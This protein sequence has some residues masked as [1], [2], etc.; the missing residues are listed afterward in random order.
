[1]QRSSGRRREAS[2]VCQ[3]EQ[4]RAKRIASDRD[5]GYASAVVSEATHADPADG[6]SRDIERIVSA[7]GERVVQ[8]LADGDT[9]APLTLDAIGAAVREA[10]G[11]LAAALVRAERLAW[12]GRQTAT[13]VHE[14]R[15]PLSVIETSAFIVSEAARGNE[16][17]LR[18]AQRIS[19]QVARASALVA[20]LL[21]GVRDDAA[22]AGPVDVGAVVRRAVATVPRPPGVQLALDVPSA[23]P[24]AHAESRRLGQIVVNLLQNALD[25]LGGTGHITVEVVAAAQQVIVRVADSGPGIDPSVLAGLFDPLVTAKSRGTGLGLAFARDTV[26]AWGGD[27]VAAGA[28]RRGARF[29]VGLQLAPPG[30]T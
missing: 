24:L 27:L 16:R 8:T 20:D 13:V 3:R 5:S 25:A 21:A 14:L 7:I 1:M 11:P 19:E 26:R 23:L 29:E 9:Q 15:N 10:I 28:E 22:A 6:N 18:H 17:L 4:P 30:K 2:N 12:A